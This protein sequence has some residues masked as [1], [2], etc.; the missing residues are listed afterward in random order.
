VAGA[1]KVWKIEGAR[2][3]CDDFFEWV[4]PLYDSAIKR[5]PLKAMRKMTANPSSFESCPFT[6]SAFSRG[7]KETREQ[8]QLLSQSNFQQLDP[9]DGRLLQRSTFA[10]ASQLL[11]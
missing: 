4:W 10:D 1:T 2:W 7:T 5:R 8:L 11:C 9:T 6:F 3:W